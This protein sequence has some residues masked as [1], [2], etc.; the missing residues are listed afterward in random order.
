MPPNDQVG[1]PTAAPKPESYVMFTIQEQLSRVAQWVER[2]F[3]CGRKVA[4]D[5]C[6]ETSSGAEGVELGGNVVTGGSEAWLF[7]FGMEFS[8]RRWIYTVDGCLLTSVTPK[9]LCAHQSRV[10]W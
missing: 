2:S 7:G 10:A 4:G 9:T 5:R 3:L 6:E 8:A 1:D